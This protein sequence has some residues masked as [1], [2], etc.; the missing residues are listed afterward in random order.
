MDERRDE[1]NAIHDEKVRCEKV[2]MVFGSK[3]FRFVSRYFLRRVHFSFSGSHHVYDI[4]SME[5]L[6]FTD[7]KRT[8]CMRFSC[9]NPHNPL[10][11]PYINSMFNFGKADAEKDCF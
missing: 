2:V 3:N 10:V 8:D 5:A 9:V 4:S 6:N 1:L 7:M 11:I